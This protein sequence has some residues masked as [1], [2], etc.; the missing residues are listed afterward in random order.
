MARYLE[1]APFN[2][3]DSKISLRFA[4]GNGMPREIWIAF[5]N[6][7]NIRTINEFYAST[8]GNVNI[9]NNT[10]MAAG[11]CGII[12]PGFNWIYPIGIF[13]YDVETEELIRRLL[14]NSRPGI[15]AQAD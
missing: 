4:W 13:R 15:V 12:P 11:A 5:Q 9:F 8:E 14:G 6:R 2:P 3:L 7:Y 10:G 1:S